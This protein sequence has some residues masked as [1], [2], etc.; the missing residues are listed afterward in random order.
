MD[1]ISQET[2]LANAAEASAKLRQRRQER[3]E[4]EAYLSALHSQ[5]AAGL[6]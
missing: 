1:L 4:V 6:R 2:A 5:I 3:D